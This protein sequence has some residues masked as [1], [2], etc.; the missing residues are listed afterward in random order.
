MTL[1]RTQTQH[2]LVALESHLYLLNAKLQI[3]DGAGC[4]T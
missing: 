2:F 1:N 4:G 3:L